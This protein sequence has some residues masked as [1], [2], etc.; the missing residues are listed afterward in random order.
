[1][2][3][4]KTLVVLIDTDELAVRCNN[5]NMTIQEFQKQYE[6]INRQKR[7]MDRKQ[8]PRKNLRKLTQN[9]QNLVSNVSKL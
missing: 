9:I 5:E 8:L 6:Y 4:D 7:Y 3:S 2:C 1:M